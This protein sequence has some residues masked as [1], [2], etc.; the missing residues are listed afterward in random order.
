MYWPTLAS[1]GVGVVVLL[2]FVDEVDVVGAGP[3]DFGGRYYGVSLGYH[4]RL[5]ALCCHAPMP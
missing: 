4:D 3:T 5:L 1:A 2:C